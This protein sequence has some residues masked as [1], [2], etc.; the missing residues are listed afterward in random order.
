MTNLAQHTKFMHVCTPP[1][2]N[3]CERHSK[4]PGL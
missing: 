1:N 3:K 2:Y 4:N